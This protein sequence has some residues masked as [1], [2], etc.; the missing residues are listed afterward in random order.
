MTKQ[1]AATQ[2]RRWFEAY[3]AIVNVPGKS[4]LDEKQFTLLSSLGMH[5][6]REAAGVPHTADFL[7]FIEEIE[8]MQL[9]KILMARFGD[10]RFYPVSYSRLLIYFV[11]LACDR[12][13][14]A[15]ML[16]NF[17]H[18]KQLMLGGEP[19]PINIY[20]FAHLCTEGLPDEEDAHRLWDLQKAK[21]ENLLDNVGL[22]SDEEF[23]T[24]F[25][26]CEVKRD[27]H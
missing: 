25:R 19:R 13:A 24:L 16:T 23:I 6:R 17:L 12:P 20:E 22:F 7:G 21:G 18:M 9:C 1:E 11:S 4:V 27:A 3:D 5:E 14:T 10:T 26:S 2:L 15:V 8:K